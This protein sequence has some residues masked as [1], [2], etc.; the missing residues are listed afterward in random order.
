MSSQ[1]SC[2]PTSRRGGPAGRRF[3]LE[4]EPADEVVLVEADEPAE[5]DLA[6]GVVLLGVQGVPGRRVVDL[7]QDEAGLEPHDVE[8]EHARR[9]DRR[10]RRPAAISASHTSAARSAGIH[11][12]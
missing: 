5:P 12:S 10:R 8:G 1:S 2:R 7:E 3:A 11:S 6:R 4:C 9:P